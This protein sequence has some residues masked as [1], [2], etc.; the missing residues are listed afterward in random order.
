MKG[1]KSNKASSPRVY[2]PT[3]RQHWQA[4]GVF[5][6]DRIWVCFQHQPLVLSGPRQLVLPGSA[7]GPRWTSELEGEAETCSWG[8]LVCGDC[9]PA[10]CSPSLSQGDF[11]LVPTFTLLLALGG[12]MGTSGSQWDGVGASHGNT[13]LEAIFWVDPAPWEA[14]HRWKPRSEWRMSQGCL[15]EVTFWTARRSFCS[16]PW[17]SHWGVFSSINI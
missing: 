13:R 17:F 5:T 12:H 8:P 6:Q 11:R 2:N 9:H 15:V 10:M 4:S 14:G 7:W 1:G 3:P 16:Q